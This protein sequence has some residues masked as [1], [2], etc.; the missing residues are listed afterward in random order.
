MVPLNEFC[1]ARA[2]ATV[3][4]PSLSP[5]AIANR[6]LPLRPNHHDFAA[7]PGLRCL[8]IEITSL[9]SLS[10]RSVQVRSCIPIQCVNPRTTYCGDILRMTLL[11]VSA[12]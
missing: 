9:V 8:F 5:I 10:A 2:S 7:A 6:V 4:V 3:Q 11:S 1:F 12:T